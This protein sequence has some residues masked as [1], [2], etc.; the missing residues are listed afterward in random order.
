MVLAMDVDNTLERVSQGYGSDL[1]GE[2]LRDEF[3]DDFE[4]FRELLENGD[5]RAAE[6]NEDGEWEANPRVKQGI[7]LAFALGENAPFEGGYMQF[8]DKD[9]LPPQGTLEEARVV[10]GG[11][12]IRS[13]AYVGDIIQ[14]PP[15]YINVGAHVGD[16]TM[17]DSEALVASAA[18]IGENVHLSTGAKTGGVLEPVEESP[19]IVEDDAFLGGNTGVYGGVVVREGAVLAPGTQISSSTPIYDTVE[20]E[21]YTGEVPENAV[22]IPGSVEYAEVQGES[23]SKQVPV[24]AKYKDAS[25]EAETALEGVLR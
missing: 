22:V 11:S 2:N 15:S 12:S 10:P 13:G 1:E 5:V 24:V 3:M 8:Q 6:K 16:G 17:V 21:I 14:M 25:T 23:V 9:T 4:D 18:Q 7:L 20:D 19:V